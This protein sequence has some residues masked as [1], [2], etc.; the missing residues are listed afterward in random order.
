M[1]SVIALVSGLGDLFAGAFLFLAPDALAARAGLPASIPPIFRELN[2]VFLL[3]V[4][5]G[6]VLPWRDPD[7]YRGY[8]W[9]MGPLLKGVGAG[10]FVLDYTLRGSSASFLLFAAF[11]GTLAVVTLWALLRARNAVARQA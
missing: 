4:G 3:A 5:I 7:R 9:V 11:D 8:L 6:Y 2:A 10:A 1:L